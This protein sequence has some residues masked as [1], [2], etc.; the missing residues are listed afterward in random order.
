M[1]SLAHKIFIKLS[2][3]QVEY[4]NYGDSVT[5]QTGSQTLMCTRNHLSH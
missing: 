1:K 5:L 3:V 4:I 2:D